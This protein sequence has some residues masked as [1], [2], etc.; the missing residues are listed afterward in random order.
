MSKANLAMSCE[1]L[2]FFIALI[3]SFVIS[4]LSGLSI[5]TFKRILKVYF[6]DV[7]NEPAA[8]RKKI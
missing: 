5:R 2:S 3:F 8:V 1:A 6:F 7:L 4:I